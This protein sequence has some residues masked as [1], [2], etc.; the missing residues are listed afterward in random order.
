MN[1][2]VFFRVILCVIAIAAISATIFFHPPGTTSTRILELRA[3]FV[4]ENGFQHK[5][6]V[7]PEL[8]SDKNGRGCSALVLLEDGKELGP[9]HSFHDDISR[10]GAGAFYHPG[11]ILYF[12]TSDNTDPNTNGRAYSIRYQQGLSP[13]VYIAAIATIYIISVWLIWKLLG[14]L[15]GRF[16]RLS[17]VFFNVINIVLLLA[18]VEACFW[19]VTES[20]LAASGPMVRQWYYSGLGDCKKG[21]IPP[22]FP[23]LSINYLEHQYLDYCLNPQIAYCG[24]KQF[25]DRY[26]IRRGEEIRPREQVKWRVI[27]LGG[28]T[29]FGEGIPKE[30]DT[31]P[32][33]LELR[34][35]KESGD[36][37]EVI[38]CGVGGY[39]IVENI[40]HYMVLLR[41]L[42][43]DMVI[44]YTG[45]NDVHA[46]LFGNI[47]TDYSNYR[48]P[49]RSEAGPF[50]KAREYLKE[51]Y[52][53]RFYFLKA[54]V[55]KTMD[56]GI[57]GKVSKKG[58]KPSE[59]AEALKRN[60]SDVYRNHLEDFITL[61]QSRKARI[62]VLPQYFVAKN[63]SDKIF[64]K[65]VEE[66]NA[67]NEQL[68]AAHKAPYGGLLLARF[69]F[70]NMQTFDNCHFNESGSKRMAELVFG[71]LKENKLLP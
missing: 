21:S 61:L 17:G 67:V 5:A 60:S 7:P 63:D 13:F 34:V 57:A 6:A 2:R 25:N 44:L 9:A 51:S 42:E 23:G 18:A 53:Y 16:P 33:Q 24:V 3:P 32:Y 8:V 14:L 55:L 69:A 70:N 59:W 37:C 20:E 28:S 52:A 62:V 58:P 71:F 26:R 1:L 30:Q 12:S 65:G 22:Q 56:E 41:D 54:V 10:K 19:A 45:I 36:D 4:L 48:V 11:N 46:R 50:P 31:W 38:N 29:T 15:L 43:P 64:M 66:H 49:W 47:V 39:T 27:V 68:A 35:R 40:I